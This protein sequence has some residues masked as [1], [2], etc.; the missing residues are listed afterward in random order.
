MSHRLRLSILAGSVLALLALVGCSGGAAVAEVDA[1]VETDAPAVEV[2]ARFSG[3]FRHEASV[4]DIAV[5]TELFLHDD[6]LQQ[7]RNGF[8]VFDAP[9]ETTAESR[10]RMRFDCLLEEGQ[11]LVWPLEIDDEGQL[12]HRAMPEMRYVRADL[13]TP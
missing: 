4:H 6:G 3:H 11:P 13:E 9:C 10:R 2:A 1:P 12:F 5:V 8:V 7:Q